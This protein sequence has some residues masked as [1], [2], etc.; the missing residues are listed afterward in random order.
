MHIHYLITE[1]CR[2]SKPSISAERHSTLVSQLE[3]LGVHKNLVFPN[4][5]QKWVMVI[6]GD[7][8]C[9]LP[10]PVIKSRSSVSPG[11]TSVEVTTSAAVK[12]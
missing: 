3:Q 7:L 4:Y 6:L 9:R 11:N 12:V 10:A 2:V 5:K 8:N 1:T